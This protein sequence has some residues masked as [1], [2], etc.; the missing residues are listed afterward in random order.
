M[1]LAGL[2][3]AIAQQKIAVSDAEKILAAEKARL[4]ELET[5][6]QQS[7]TGGRR[8]TDQERLECRRAIRTVL[9]RQSTV[10]EICERLPQY[11]RGLIEHE[12]SF[13]LN[14]RALVWTHGRGL[15]SKYA[16]A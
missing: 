15:A 3:Q 9:D 2:L 16:R 12:V 10:G 11:D 14:R 4:A 6:S 1:E 13:L 7:Y 8:V 5:Q